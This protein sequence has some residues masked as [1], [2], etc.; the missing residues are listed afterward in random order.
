[1]TR[2]QKINK[3]ID[4]ANQGAG[5]YLFCCLWD[6]MEDH[7]VTVWDFHDQTDAW[8]EA[9][10]GCACEAYEHIPYE[11]LWDKIICTSFIEREGHDGIARRKA[12]IEMSCLISSG[13]EL[14]IKDMDFANVIGDGLVFNSEGRIEQGCGKEDC[15][16]S[17]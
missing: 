11:E 2:K 14:S 6:M 16:Q 17:N 1:M 7:E 9:V 12:S 5:A 4:F 3:V 15:C 10:V 8:K 13:H